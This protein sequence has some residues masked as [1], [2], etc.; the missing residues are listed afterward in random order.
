MKTLR[1][2]GTLA[3]AG[4][5]LALVS[6]GSATAAPGDTVTTFTV[7]GGDLVLS[8][9]TVA[10]L[11]VVAT[12][13]TS[14]TGSLGEVVVTD[15]RGGT[16][17]WTV[18]AGSTAFVNTTVGGPTSTGV[19]YDAGTVVETGDVATTV[20]SRAVSTPVAVVTA[21][22]VTGNNTATFDPSLTV[23][24]PTNALAGEF[25]GTVTTSVA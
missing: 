18:T 23:T 14:V 10:D 7:E 17:G 13:E 1:T 21:D 2:L 8:A 25:E 6:V 9:A 11:D 3:I 15:S 20:N 12:G 4:S 22:N 5:V 24:L 19:A 16:E